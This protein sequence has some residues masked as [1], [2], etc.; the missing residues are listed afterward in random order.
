LGTTSAES[1]AQYSHA[2]FIGSAKLPNGKPAFGLG[3]FGLAN[4]ASSSSDRKN[5]FAPNLQIFLGA[6]ALVGFA[7]A[8]VGARWWRQGAPAAGRHPPVFE[9]QSSLAAAAFV[10]ET[11]KKDAEQPDST[12]VNM[13]DAVNHVEG[14]PDIQTAG[15]PHARHVAYLG[16]VAMAVAAIP[17]VAYAVEEESDEGFDLRILAV[18]AFPLLAASWALFNVW[19]VAARQVVRFS[20]TID[21]GAKQGLRAED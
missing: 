8:A 7:T 21:G 2:E 16:A 12:A 13:G 18:L 5:R 9:M 19:R 6:L 4:A 11:S 1:L 20:S 14:G 15:S 10:G 3:R 17:A